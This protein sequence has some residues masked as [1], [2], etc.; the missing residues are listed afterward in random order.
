[1]RRTITA[2]FVVLLLAATTTSAQASA[3]LPKEFDLKPQ[4]DSLGL[5]ARMQGKRGTCAFFAMAAMLEFE[6]SRTTDKHEQQFSPEFLVWASKEATGQ[7]GG[8]F[9]KILQGLNL[10]G[11]CTL[12]GMPYAATDDP[13]R[14]PSAEA[15]AD[16]RENALRWQVRWI[17]RMDTKLSLSDQELNA[18]K[19][20]LTAGHPVGCGFR[21]PK[22]LKGHVLGE[23]SKEDMA[24]GGSHAIVIVGYQDDPNRPGGGV[25]RFRN[26]WSTKWGEEGYGVISYAYART[27]LID[28]VWLTYGA[29]ESEKP[30]ARFLAP[31]MTIL[32]KN[33]CEAVNQEMKQ[34][35]RAMWSE[36]KQLFCKAK[37]GGWVEL[38]FTVTKAGRYRV[39]VLGTVAPDYGTIAVA[40][41]GKSVPGSFNLY[42][43]RVTPS[44]SLELGNHELE[45]GQHTIRFRVVDKSEGST[46]YYFGIDAVDL[47]AVVGKQ[48]QPTT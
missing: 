24:G 25:L 20:T 33:Q 46:N 36:G 10:H 31:A 40:L 48:T 21:W 29:P 5:P 22:K 12:D 35:G 17:R 3:P 14:K 28:A 32:A 34:F 45:A 41:N 4:F 43:E 11:V 8:A 9:Y 39:R 2:T 1:M 13:N 38:G 16:A 26:S 42:S 18:I 7:T 19:K 27:N 37:K 6:Y 30:L 44:G 47:L 23:I 15:Q